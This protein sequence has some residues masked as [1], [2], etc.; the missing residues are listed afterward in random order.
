MADIYFAIRT[1]T[2]E[3]KSTMNSGATVRA[4]VLVKG[5]TTPMTLDCLACE[6]AQ[7]WTDPLT[8]ICF[9]TPGKL[10]RSEQMSNIS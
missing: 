5:P 2:I 7:A 3:M 1:F 4:W 10:C 6:P 8:E 9:R